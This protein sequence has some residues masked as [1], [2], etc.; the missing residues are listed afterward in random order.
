MTN[1]TTIKAFIEALIENPELVSKIKKGDSAFEIAA[2]LGIDLAKED[3][4]APV[5]DEGELSDSDLESVTGGTGRGIGELI[6]CIGNDTAPPKY[7]VENT[8]KTIFGLIKC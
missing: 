1:Q 8:I 2:S 6:K 7:V 3:L 4:E 5:T